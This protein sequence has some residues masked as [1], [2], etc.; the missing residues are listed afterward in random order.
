MLVVDGSVAKSCSFSRD[1]AGAERGPCFAWKGGV[2]C[3]K[4]G[5]SLWGFNY[6]GD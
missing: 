2:N 3:G 1:I 4:P 5:G 6:T